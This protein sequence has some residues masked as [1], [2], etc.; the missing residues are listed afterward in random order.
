MRY[1]LRFNN[2]PNL[3]NDMD[4][5]VSKYKWE[6]NKP[7]KDML[8]IPK[9]DFNDFKITENKKK[10]NL[11]T[12][13]T[14]EEKAKGVESQIKKWYKKIELNEMENSHKI[15]IESALNRIKKE[16]PELGIKEVEMKNFGKNRECRNAPQEENNIKIIEKLIES[17]EVKASKE[18]G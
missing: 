4:E 17:G 13:E 6:E 1:G 10:P 3:S 14:M 12:I 8:N 5:M 15:E 16:S 9:N 11:K 2:G 7:I 18:N